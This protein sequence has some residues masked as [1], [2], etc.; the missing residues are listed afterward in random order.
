MK[1]RVGA[2]AAS[3]GLIW[4]GG[5]LI[6]G[7]L[8]LVWPGYAAAFLHAA[9]G[10][11]AGPSLGQVVLGAGYGL[12]DGAMFGLIGGAIYNAFAE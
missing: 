5:I 3:A 10:Y 6:A 11:D 2:L 4:G 9:A 1:L 7:I 12:A 8:G